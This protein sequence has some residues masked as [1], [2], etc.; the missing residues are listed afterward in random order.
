MR[1]ECERDDLSKALSAVSGV[2]LA[3]GIHPVYESVEIVASETGLELL[4]TDLE[5]GMRYRIA[6]GDALQVVG[7]GTAV[8]PAQRLAVLC[9]EMPKGKV[10]VAWNADTRECTV[11][12]GRGRF[13][14][15][16]QSP[17][18]FPEIPA[19]DESRAAAV[20][21]AVLRD[22]VRLTSFAAARERMRY[23]LNG[24]LVRVDGETL[25]C[26]ATDGRRLARATAPIRN[27][28]HAEFSAIV[29]TKG[30][31]H[32]EKTLGDGDAEVV[33]SVG[34]SHIAARTSRATVVSR[35]VEGSFP[36]YRDVIPQTCARKA[37]I[38][39]EAFAGALRRAALVTSRDAQSVRMKFDD[40][41]LTVS[42][43][44]AEGSAEE[45]I[46]CDQSGGPDSLGFNPEFLLECLGVLRGDDVV[47][48]W[49]DRKSP[50]KIVD[51][52]YTYVVMPVS[53]E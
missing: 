1:F 20:E 5:V 36:N 15:Q 51:G 24:I 35:L 52:T 25:E 29:P 28:G 26:V 39:R 7:K 45:T 31:Q 9:K 34:G 49:N 33:L 37:V 6:A 2:V 13:R 48:E 22:L 14:L 11:T 8:V 50:G 41:G 38:G 44:S 53:I 16:G 46:P 3:K 17:E 47:F 10:A 27:D 4:A 30:L 42:A 19:V 32:L 23:A 12:A 18:D 40:E 43:Q 21:T